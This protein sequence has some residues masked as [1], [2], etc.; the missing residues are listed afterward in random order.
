MGGLPVDDA[1]VSVVGE[2]AV[3]GSL[4]GDR[5]PRSTADF[6]PEGDALAVVTRDIAQGNE[7]LRRNWKKNKNKQNKQRGVGVRQVGSNLAAS[8]RL[9]TFLIIHSAAIIYSAKFK[10]KSHQTCHLDSTD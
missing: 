3:V 7:E 8:V 9:T 10:I 2:V 6:A 1:E 4:P 5:G